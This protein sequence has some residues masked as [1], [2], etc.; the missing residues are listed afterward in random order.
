MCQSQELHR[1]IW[2]QDQLI[3]NSKT[4]PDSDITLEAI[5]SRLEAIASSLE[6]I[7]IRLDAIGI[8]LEAIAFVFT[9]KNHNN[10]IITIRSCDQV[11]LCSAP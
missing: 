4:A 10:Y 3:C 7:A 9:N 6:A 5:A 8:W 11:A 2:A 1:P